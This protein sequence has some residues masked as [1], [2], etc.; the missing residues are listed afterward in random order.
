MPRGAATGV[1]VAQPDRPQDS[2]P[3]S[4]YSVPQMF[5]PSPGVSGRLSLSGFVRLLRH[6]PDLSFPLGYDAP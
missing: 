6:F 2:Y 3:A 1:P 4:E 5:V